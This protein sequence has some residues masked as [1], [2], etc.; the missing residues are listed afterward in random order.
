M[1]LAGAPLPAVLEPAPI[2][3]EQAGPVS[4]LADGETEA[5]SEVAPADPDPDGIIVTGRKEAPPGDPLVGVNEVS[6]DVVQGLDKALVAPVSMAYKSAVP[7][8]IRVGLR[9]F[10]NNLQ[11]PLVFLNY[12]LQLKP[13]KAAETVG[14]FAV[15]STVGAAGLFDIAKK[16]PFK[17]PRRNNGFGTTL[18][19][20]G[21][22]PG[23]F[24]FLPI[25]GPTSARDIVGRWLDLLVL[26]TAIGKPFSEPTYAIATTTIRAL[27]DRVEA[28]KAL[29]EIRD[30][31]RDP[32]SAMRDAYLQRRQAEIDVLKGRIP[33]PLK[34]K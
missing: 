10:L 6:Y 1:A 33:D 29:T 20:Y 22:K 23:P 19:F 14:R 5:T 21:V 30:G 26:P 15:N 24:L 16:K 9:N 12:M 32:Y 18:G 7:R 34:V 2:P 3:A 11:E 25:I 31:P 27:D 8:P 28:D 4:G 17:L 13:G